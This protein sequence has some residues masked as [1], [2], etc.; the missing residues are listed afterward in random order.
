MVRENSKA[1][2]ILFVRDLQQERHRWQISAQPKIASF[3]RN[4]AGAGRFTS[5]N[6]VT[7]LDSY[8]EVQPLMAVWRRPN[9]W[10]LK[11]KWWMEM[12]RS[13]FVSLLCFQFKLELIFV[14]LENNDRKIE[15]II[16]SGLTANM[17]S[18]G[19][20]TI[21]LFWNLLIQK[22][23]IWL[24]LKLII[25][26]CFRPPPSVISPP[27]VSAYTCGPR[28]VNRRVTVNY[29]DGYH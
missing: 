22:N 8:F 28:L 6:W 15:W 12:L 7:F 21:R 3:L 2:R 24:E 23:K 18:F 27:V 5:G 26:L 1:V 19:S 9:K 29:L 14:S 11:R 25:I 16:C 10:K 20:K 4:T 13:E 17:L